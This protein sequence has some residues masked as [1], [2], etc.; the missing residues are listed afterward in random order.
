[1]IFMVL[2]QKKQDNLRITVRA[3]H[4]VG[5]VQ[6]IDNAPGGTKSYQQPSM[7]KVQWLK[8]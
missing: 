5:K 4:F 7:E 8:M 1:M 3:Q 2:V 6:Q